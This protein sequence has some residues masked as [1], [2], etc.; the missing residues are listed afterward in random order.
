MPG[1]QRVVAEDASQFAVE[2]V[3]VRVVAHR[4]LDDPAEHF[5]I[6]ALFAQREKALHNFYLFLVIHQT[7]S[8]D[9][10]PAAGGR[11]VDVPC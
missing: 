10:G 11:R 3:G 9:P 2:D 7:R 1:H 6:A 5:L 4:H 8:L